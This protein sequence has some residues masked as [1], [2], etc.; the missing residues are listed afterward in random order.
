MV[1]ILNVYAPIAL[2][3]FLAGTLYKILRHIVMM[4]TR[5][6]P[7]GSTQGALDAPEPM[8]WGEAFKRVIFYPIAMFPRRSNPVWTLGFALYHVGI[9]TT[10][11]G[12]T[13]AGILLA[14][15]VAA[16][17]PVPDVAAGLAESTNYSAA[18]LVS[19]IFADAEPTVANFLFGGFGPTFAAITWIDVLCALTGNLLMLFVR[20]KRLSGA[21][22]RDLDAPVQGVRVS[23]RRPPVNAFVTVVITG[24]IWSEILARLALVPNI[25]LLHALFGLTLLLIFPFSYLWHMLYIWVAFV[26]AAARRR[27]GALA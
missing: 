25:V 8:S 20:A 5:R 1:A 6:R 23:G 3:V 7:M 18:N 16:G 11:I 15:R 13:I 27:R 10:V 12:Y 2:T 9:I 22:T 21:V 14:G 17:V 19:L 4:L 26:Y 24:I